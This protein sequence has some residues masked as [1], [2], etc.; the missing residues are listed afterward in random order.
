MYQ[1]SKQG[2]WTAIGELYL[3]LDAVIWVEKRGDGLEKVEDVKEGLKACVP[4]QGILCPLWRGEPDMVAPG[5]VAKN[6]VT[7]LDWDQSTMV[8]GDGLK[9]IYGQ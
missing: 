9:D 7:M 4:W 5:I 1:D 6:L 8:L 3:D 2:L